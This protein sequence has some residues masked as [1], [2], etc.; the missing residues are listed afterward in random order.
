MPSGMRFLTL[1][2]I[3]FFKKFIVFFV[4]SL[5]HALAERADQVCKVPCKNLRNQIKRRLL[6]D[7]LVDDV[8][9][10]NRLH[11]TGR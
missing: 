10:K 4:V 1:L 3:F 5:K 8:L 6:F 9:S 11:C 2:E 7:A